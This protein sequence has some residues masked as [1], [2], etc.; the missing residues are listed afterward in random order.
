MDEA[1]LAP[2]DIFTIIAFCMRGEGIKPRII[3][4][5]TPRSDNWLTRYIKDNEIPIITAKTSDNK[6]ISQEQLDLMRKTCI[7]DSSW[8]R[9]FYGEECEDDSNGTIFS[10]D[11]ISKA[12][13]NT[14]TDNEGFCIRY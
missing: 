5:S 8:K 14:F 9:E 13:K 12:S 10:A 11:L 4:A 7:D 2:A 1:A 6:T 3:L